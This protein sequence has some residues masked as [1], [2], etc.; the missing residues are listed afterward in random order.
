MPHS[1]AEMKDLDVRSAALTFAGMVIAASVH[2]EV[3][4]VLPFRELTTATPTGHLVLDVPPGTQASALQSFDA[5][6]FVEAT[7]AAAVLAAADGDPFDPSN[8]STKLMWLAARAQADVTYQ[9]MPGVYV[10]YSYANEGVIA[11]VL[12]TVAAGYTLRLGLDVNGDGLAQAGETLCTSVSTLTA[13]AR[14]IYRPVDTAHAGFGSRFWVLVQ[15]PAGSP[16]Q[17]FAATLSGAINYY[18]AQTFPYNSTPSRHA[19]PNG[20]TVTLGPGS[21]PAGT[22]FSLRTTWLKPLPAHKRIY[23]TL[24]MGSAHGLFGQTDAVLP[25]A[26]TYTAQQSDEQAA[27][28]LGT[29]GVPGAAALIVPPG[30]T[31]D[32]V[33]FD[34]PQADNYNAIAVS[35]YAAAGIDLNGIDVKVVRTDF[36][37]ADVS[38]VI[39]P[40]PSV[41]SLADPPLTWNAGATSTGTIE[42]PRPGRWY[43]AITNSG[44][45]EVPLNVSVTDPA[46]GS[47]GVPPLGATPTP[48]LAE[49]AYF[50]LQRGGHGIF[51]SRASGQQVVDWYTFLEDGTPVFYVA[52]NPAPP[53]NSG[54]WTAP[55][56]RAAW[57]PTI[58]DF[59]IVQIAGSISLIP[60]SENNMMYSWQLEGRSGSEAFTLLA[61]TGACPS[62]NGVATNF[63]GNWFAPGESGYG[64]DVLAL[65]EQ[66]FDTFYLYDALGNPTWVIG[67]NGP[68]ATSST[69]DLVQSTGFCPSCAWRALTTRPAGTMS[70]SFASATSGHWNTAITLNPPLSGDW[71][72]NQA[73]LRLTGSPACQ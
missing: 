8:P 19:D 23:S 36:P 64:V 32:R 29:S 30:E 28:L 5:T 48:T 39:A 56:Y 44:A 22:A 71:N 58:K 45:T 7:Q 33:F 27:I 12:D 50:N 40:A 72:V 11:E 63:N 42:H 61:R 57:N 26:L 18:A 59:T 66:Q 67:A 2:A 10:T 31:L 15:A 1:P 43:V 21:A 24:L 47:A 38:P 41:P 69:L 70:V 9:D 14:C 60:T 3:A 17:T 49:G 55:L 16:N 65:P 4:T 37:A 68:F 6:P 51:L 46:Y 34:L 54:W 52:Q 53:S 25:F 35:I 13:Q 62:V 20:S 73:T